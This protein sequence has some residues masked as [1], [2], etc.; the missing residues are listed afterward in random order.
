MERWTEVQIRGCCKVKCGLWAGLLSEEKRGRVRSSEDSCLG[1]QTGGRIGMTGS[2]WILMLL[3]L[4]LLML[5]KR[6]IHA[7]VRK[8]EALQIG[9]EHQLCMTFEIINGLISQV[10]FGDPKT[11]RCPH[12]SR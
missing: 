3:V 12:L 6:R 5:M 4:L 7:T 9:H 11:R 2:F 8:T 10:V 1:E